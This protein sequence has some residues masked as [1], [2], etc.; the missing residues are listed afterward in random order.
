[1]SAFRRVRELFTFT[2]NEQ[3]IFFF[4]SLVL[5]AGA[6]I[7]AYRAAFPASPPVGQSFEYRNSD[8]VFAARSASVLSEHRNMP[9]H[10]AGALATVN[11]NTAGL[12]ELMQLPGVGETT[13]ARILAYRREHERFHSADELKRVRGIGVKKFEKIRPSITLGA[14]DSSDH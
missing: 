1:M 14:V 4:L 6:G 5:L 7:K 8:S 9:S 12:R 2:K 11:I 10:K 3:K 13:A